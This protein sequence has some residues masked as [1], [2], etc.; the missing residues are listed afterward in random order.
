[1]RRAPEKRVVN[2]SSELMESARRHSES[3]DKQM[4]VPSFFEV[5]FLGGLLRV[6]GPGSPRNAEEAKRRL[7]AAAW[8][9]GHPGDVNRARN[10]RLRWRLATLIL[11][12][13]VA[14]LTWVWIVLFLLESIRVLLCSGGRF[15]TR[16]DD[17]SFLEFK[18]R[19]PPP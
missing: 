2:V 11:V 10:V 14:V 9:S 13:P 3:L 7:Q 18:S 5:E 12:A 16:R 15:G 19:N 1:M 17:W 8:L 4:N 6:R